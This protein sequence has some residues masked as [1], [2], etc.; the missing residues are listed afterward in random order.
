[1]AGEVEGEYQAT[2]RRG[3]VGATGGCHGRR[4]DG[5]EAEVAWEVGNLGSKWKWD[6]AVDGVAA[7]VAV[8]VSLG[9]PPGLGCP[10]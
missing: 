4:R 1:M 10:E 7:A 6:D 8:T 2:R 5:G 3:V 9:D